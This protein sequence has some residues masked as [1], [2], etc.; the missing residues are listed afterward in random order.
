LVSDMIE[1]IRANPSARSAYDCLTYAGGPA[2]HGCV[3]S[4]GVTAASCS[5]ADLAED[6]LA[7]WQNAARSALPL[8]A[9]TCGANV[10]YVAAAAADE[11]DRYRVSVSWR[12][13]D[14]TE[15]LTYESDLL[16]ASP[17]GEGLP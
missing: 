16:L 15:A 3:S 12:A 11:A 2:E 7:R 17:T 1:R 8:D 13:R 10:A 6:D 5:P 4:D 14:E 9:G